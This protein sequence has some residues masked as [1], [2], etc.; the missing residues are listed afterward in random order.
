MQNDI[1]IE[2][3]EKLYL[4]ELIK[5][6]NFSIKEMYDIALVQRLYRFETP[7]ERRKWTEVDSNFIIENKDT[8]SVKEVSSI[9]HK[10]YNATL[11]K[12]KLLGL[13]E[14]IN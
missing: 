13:Y 8:L 14:M 3:C 12:V 9:M 6:Y 7:I 4:S 10:S 5:K 1:H 11:Q 2:D